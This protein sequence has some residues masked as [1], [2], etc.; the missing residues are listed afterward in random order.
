MDL[1]TSKVNVTDELKYTH[2]TIA[3]NCK[4]EDIVHTHPRLK[5][6]ILDVDTE[7]NRRYTKL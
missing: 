2:A 3:T 4:I 1:V 6:A 5:F 7:V